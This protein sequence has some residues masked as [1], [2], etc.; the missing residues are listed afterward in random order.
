MK[1]VLMMIKLALT[2]KLVNA[3]AKKVAAKFWMKKIGTDGKL[4]INELYAVENEG[5]V[6]L[7]IDAELEV[8]SEIAESL[9]NAL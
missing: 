6:K 9:I 3:L 2:N 8:S 7:R 4:T 1:G 5:R